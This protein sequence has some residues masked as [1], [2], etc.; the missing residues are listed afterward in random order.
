MDHRPTC[1]MQNHKFPENNIG[2]NAYDL[3]N[4][5]FLYTTL[6]VQFMKEIISWT[7]LKF[8]TSAKDSI[9]IMKR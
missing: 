2:E 3:E 9:K 7:L 1:K 6:E 5:D 4:D 8:K